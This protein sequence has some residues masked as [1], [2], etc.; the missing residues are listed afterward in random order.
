MLKGLGSVVMHVQD[1]DAAKAWYQDVIGHPPYF[2]EPFY[3]GF[4]IS[5]YE[6]GLHPHDGEHPGAGAVVAYWRVDDV[7]VEYDRLIAKG[8]KP[9]FEPVDV[10][11]G[12]VAAS[13]IDPFGNVLG[14]MYNPHFQAK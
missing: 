9:H 1:L 12:I 3:V 10:G 4:D 7:S 14:L 8:A 6:L 11:D 13:I 5:G 2:D